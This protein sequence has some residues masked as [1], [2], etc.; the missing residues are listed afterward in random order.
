MNRQ[1][2]TFTV[3][4]TETDNGMPVWEK[5]QRYSRMRHL[6]I[7]RAIGEPTGK[8]VI[9]HV[10]SGFKVGK[11]FQKLAH[12]RKALPILLQLADWS[13]EAEVY[14]NN[15]TLGDKVADICTNDY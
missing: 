9:T 4:T 1:K 15:P 12:A 3:Q 13:K 14:R 2:L 6:I 8:Y 7:T 11:P 10:M 5:T